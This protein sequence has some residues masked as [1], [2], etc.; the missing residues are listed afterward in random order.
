[1]IFPPN[2]RRKIWEPEPFSSYPIPESEESSFYIKKKTFFVVVHKCSGGVI[3][4][5]WSSLVVSD[6]MTS[7]K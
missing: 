2:F 1:M 4:T 7:G 6:A 5:R 3:P